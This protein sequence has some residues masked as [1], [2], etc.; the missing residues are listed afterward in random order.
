CDGYSYQKT[1]PLG[2]VVAEAENDA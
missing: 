2:P 1:R